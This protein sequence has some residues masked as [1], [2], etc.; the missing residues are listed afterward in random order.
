MHPVAL[1]LVVITSVAVVNVNDIIERKKKHATQ[2]SYGF[3]FHEFDSFQVLHLPRILWFQSTSNF[4]C[5][6]EQTS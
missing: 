2:S 3:D 4:E 5:P 1:A 6:G